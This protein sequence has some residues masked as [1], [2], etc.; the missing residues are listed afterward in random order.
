LQW[1]G[2]TTQEP[3]N[4]PQRPPLNLLTHRTAAPAAAAAVVAAAPAERTALASA[5]RHVHEALL[6][7]PPALSVTQPI[8]ALPA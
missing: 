3:L 2:L 6:C 5:D 4:A 8:V 7:G 1:S